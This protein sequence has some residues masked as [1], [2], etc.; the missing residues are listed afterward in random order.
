LEQAYSLKKQHPHWLL[1]GE[2]NEM[3]PEGFDY[4]NSPY[5]IKDAEVRDKTI[6]H[7]TSSGTQ[8]IVNAVHAEELIT[9]SFV[10]AGAIARYI[11]SKNPQYVSLC[12]MGYATLYPTE[13]DTFC[14]E[15]IR[16]LITGEAYNYEHAIETI[17]VTS[18]SRFF[19]NKPHAPVE[20]FYM[21]T[22]KNIF[23]FV[24]QV[25]KNKDNTFNITRFD[26]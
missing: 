24:L 3:K 23:N 8:G 2:R 13:E 15:Y 22:K 14:A 5:L 10:N 9:G 7:T 12:C 26:I 21:C 25:N 16:A 11:K 6:I 20:D 19:D 18:G 17:K 4:G 1:I